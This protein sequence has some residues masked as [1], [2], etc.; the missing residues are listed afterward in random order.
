[1]LFSFQFYFRT[2]LVKSFTAAVLLYARLV[3]L[4]E[5]TLVE[6]LVGRRWAHCQTSDLG[7]RL[8]TPAHIVATQIRHRNVSGFSS[9]FKGKLR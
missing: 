1:M 9:A 4:L 6:V 5:Q 3:S 8:R 2:K 7:E